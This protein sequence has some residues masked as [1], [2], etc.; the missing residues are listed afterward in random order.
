LIL[1]KLDCQIK[2]EEADKTSQV[3]VVRECCISQKESQCGHGV[4]PVWNG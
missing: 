4:L 1:T 3:S 2:L